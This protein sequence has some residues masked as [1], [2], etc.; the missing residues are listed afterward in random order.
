[1]LL[2]MSG[3]VCTQETLMSDDGN[4]LSDDGNHRSPIF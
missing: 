1:M 4:H 3:T 2:E